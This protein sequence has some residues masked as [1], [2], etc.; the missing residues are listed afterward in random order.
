LTEQTCEHH[1][2]CRNP[3]STPG[4]INLHS[5]WANWFLPPPNKTEKQTANYNHIWTVQGAGEVLNL[6]QGKGVG[7][8]A[9]LSIE[10]SVKHRK[11]SEGWEEAGDNPLPK[12]EQIVDHRADILNQRAAFKIELPH[13]SGGGADK[14]AA[15]G[16]NNRS[17]H[18]HDL[19]NLPHLTIS[20][21]LVERRTKH[22][23]QANHLVRP[24]QSFCLYVNTRT[25]CWRNNSRT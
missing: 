13:F 9:K 5:H 24:C 25:R 23:S 2:P 3:L 12:A 6:Y 14:T 17:D 22:Y 16:E 11:G 20:I 19:A 18:L 8:G 10:L 7:Q 21:K 15:D 4:S 1:A